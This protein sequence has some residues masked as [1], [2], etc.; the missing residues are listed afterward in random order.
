MFQAYQNFAARK[1][2]T[3]VRMTAQRNV[4]VKELDGLDGDGLWLKILGEHRRICGS[5][6]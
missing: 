4:I 5:S 2:A 6:R 1:M 3:N